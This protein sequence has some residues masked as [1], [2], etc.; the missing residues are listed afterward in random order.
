MKSLRT[1]LTALMLIALSGCAWQKIP[2]A[3]E[4]PAAAMPLPIRVGVVTGNDAD[5]KIFVPGVVKALRE[6]KV[7]QSIIYPYQAGEAVDAVSTINVDGEWNASGAGPYVT[8]GLT[9]GLASPFVGPSVTGTHFIKASLV[10][11]TED[12][13]FY[14]A[15]VTTKGEWGVM[16]NAKEASERTTE[17]QTKRLAEAIANA[18]RDDRARILAK[19]NGNG[20]ASQL[21]A[22]PVQQHSRH[23]PPHRTTPATPA[24]APPIYPGFIKQPVAQGIQGPFSFEA[25]RLAIRRGC[26]TTDGIRPTAYLI[27]RSSYVGIYD[28]N[29]AS[30]H[31]TV[32]CAG[33]ICG[34]E[35]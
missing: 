6:Q 13:G 16:A 10:T 17:L 4:T 35:N 24:E 11:G 15:K 32:R 20:E 21:A 9:F 34:I 28:V 27:K 14:S 12:V 19:V 8:V 22:A 3:P 23:V 18:I 30:G 29:C 5:S 31:I 1:L 33:P 2:P 7:F 26:S 25:E